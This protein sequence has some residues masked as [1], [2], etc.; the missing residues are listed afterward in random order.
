MKALVTCEINLTVALTKKRIITFNNEPDN[1][2]AVIVLDADFTTGVV[3]A[4]LVEPSPEA[5]KAL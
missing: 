3:K 1:L 5:N 2:P 4:G